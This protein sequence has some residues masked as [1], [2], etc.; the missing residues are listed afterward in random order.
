L[1][2]INIPVFLQIFYRHPF[3]LR[4]NDVKDHK[5]DLSALMLKCQRHV[6]SDYCCLKKRKMV[7]KEEDPEST[8]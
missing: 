6:C 5:E 3:S 1:F 8:K 2:T 7:R 4:Y